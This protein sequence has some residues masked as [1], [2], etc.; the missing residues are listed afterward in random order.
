M[1]LSLQ[2]S[3][4]VKAGTPK[5]HPLVLVHGL[6]NAHRWTD[7]FLRRCAE[8]WGSDRVY[9]VHL[10]GTDR[11]HDA[12]F[13]EGR[14]HMAG[15]FHRGAGCDTVERQ[16]SYLEHKLALFEKMRGLT[17]PFDVIA[18]SMGG[19]VLRRY[20]SLHP[21]D[22]AAAVTLGT[23]H[24][25]APMARDF[26][27]F[28]YVVGAGRAFSSL[29]PRRVRELVNRHPWPAHIPLYTVRAIQRGVSWGVGGELFIG[30]LYHGL[31]RRPSDG[32]VPA[33]H[34]LCEEGQHLA[35]L[36]G[37]NHLRLVSDPRVVDLCASVL[38]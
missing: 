15:E 29:T 13:P 27:W 19:L 11:I 14:V 21:D 38:P 26:L 22:V 18:H 12:H 3:E 28:G 7:A 4:S 34:A 36:P 30:T 2:S 8:I 17:R 33:E 1:T 5:A 9:V 20:V 37:Y 10:N 25:G 31:L 23:P 24:G 32:L 6:R 16:C 35:D